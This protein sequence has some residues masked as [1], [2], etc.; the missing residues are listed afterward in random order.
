MTITP[1]QLDLW[2]GNM[3]ELYQSLE[4]EIIRIIIERLKNGHEDITYWQAEKLSEL[5]LFNADVVALLASVTRVAE[6]EIKRCSKKR[7]R[8]LCRI[9][10]KLCRNRRNRC[11]TT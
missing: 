11:R 4:G 2:S 5:R 10:T 1:T 9:L 7:A 3:S 8:G 6:P